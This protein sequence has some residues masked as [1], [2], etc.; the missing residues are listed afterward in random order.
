MTDTTST[1]S[2]TNEKPKRLY[3]SAQLVVAL[4]VKVFKTYMWI[5]NWG[6]SVRYFSRHFSKA[7]GISENRVERCI[8]ALVDNRLITVT[9]TEQ[10]FLLTPNAEEHNKYF[11]IPLGQM[12]GCDKIKMAAEATWNK[13]T[14]VQ[15]S[16]I[17]DMDIDDM[18]DDQLEAVMIRLQA[19]LNERKQMKKFVKVT[20][21][22]TEK[23]DDL[24][25]LINMVK[26]RYQFWG[27]N[28]DG[29][30]EKMWSQ[31][32]KWD[33]DNRDPIQLKGYKGDNLLNE[34]KDDN[35]LASLP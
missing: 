9:N 14:P 32:F 7:I 16:K 35:P 3:P 27:R 6:G 26:K 8:Q 1:T 28:K 13:T 15:K 31:W 11:E 18:D 17:E 10:G 20:S 25:F 30:V 21:T 33:S 34:Y 24:P 29:K 19:S 22:P 23:F 12:L 2:T 4:D 5:L